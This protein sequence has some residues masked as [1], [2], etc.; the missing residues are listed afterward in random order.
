[1]QS[2]NDANN[3]GFGSSLKQKLTSVPKIMARQGEF[4]GE[5]LLKSAHILGYAD[6]FNSVREIQR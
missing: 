6:R 1:M 5:E 2:D 3:V 4:P